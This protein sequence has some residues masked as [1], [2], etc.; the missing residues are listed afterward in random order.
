MRR[1][2]LAV[3]LSAA[4]NLSSGRAQILRCAQNDLFHRAGSFPKKPI[5]VSRQ[6]RPYN[7]S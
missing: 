3:I 6:G 2:P 7:D 1:E 5:R 4:K